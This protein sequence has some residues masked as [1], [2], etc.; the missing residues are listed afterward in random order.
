MYEPA[1]EELQAIKERLSAASWKRRVE[2]ARKLERKVLAIHKRIQGGESQESALRTVVDLSQR[3]RMLRALVRYREEGFEG[4]FDRRTPREPVTAAQRMV[5]ETA[6]RT[7]PKVAVPRIIEL[8]EQQCNAKVSS[9]TVKRVLKEAG[10][11]RPVG[12]P[13]GPSSSYPLGTKVEELGAAG[14]ELLRAAEAETDAVGE[15]VDTLLELGKELPEPS[16]VSEEERALRNEKGQLTARYN[17]AHG[18]VPGEAVGPAYRTM[19]EKSAERDLGRL[20]LRSHNPPAVERRVWA[21]LA[22]PMLTKGNRF[23]ELYGPLGAHLKGI[24]G[25]AYMPETLRKSVTEFVLAGASEVLQQVHSATW[26]RVSRDRWERGY[27]ASVVYVDNTAKPL[28]SK[29]FVKSAKVATTGRVQPALVSTY[30]HS[31]A[32][33]PIHFET[34]SGTAPLAPRVLSLLKQAE[35]QSEVPVG[36]LTVIDGECCSA[37]LLAA[38]KNDERDLVTP[39][40]ATIA[41]PKRIRFGRGSAPQPFRDGDTIREGTV[42]LKDSHQRGVVVQARAIV[43]EHW[44]QS[45]DW[46]ALATLAD[47]EKWS[48]RQL[49]TLYFERWP[50]QENFFRQGNK[51]VALG[52]VQGYGKRVVANTSVLTKLDEQKVRLERKRHRLEQLEQQHQ[53]QQAALHDLDKQ[54]RRK[55]RYADKRQERVDAAMQAPRVTRKG[56]R[57]LEELKQAHTALGELA[58]RKQQLQAKYQQQEQQRQKTQGQI[59]RW[60]AE[61]AKLESRREILEAD[62]SKDTLL[63]TLKL[64]LAMLA[65]FVVVEYFPHRP[66][67]WAT[68]LT[69]LAL[70][71]GRREIT[72]DAI[73][74]YIQANPRDRDMMEALQ[75]ACEIVNKRQLSK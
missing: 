19:E 3:S 8:I 10:L 5:I 41:T 58:E 44:G 27:R 51:A 37:G 34:Y 42:E 71:P 6:R 59:K 43:I 61:Q 50:N 47:P 29:Q 57:A 62:V 1:S 9:S 75:G 4:L 65:H 64:T 56:Q 68:F 39:L 72:A 67:L 48:A 2:Q 66:M 24:C 32:G 23:D 74:T 52:R 54:V 63:T 46:T 13:S 20:K 28:W 16:E 14:F 12:R 25:Y 55:Q 11:E 33:V 49:A 30:I 73:T 21:L 36:R 31:G 18:K 17:Q 70:L 35:T 7:D 38:F 69:R 60:E 22:M 45:G 53:G 40:P 26:H 15:L